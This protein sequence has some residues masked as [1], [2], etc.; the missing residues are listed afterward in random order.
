MNQSDVVPPEAVQEADNL[1]HRFLETLGEDFNTPGA[2]AE[3]HGL[4]R[5]LEKQ[6]ATNEVSLAAVRYILKR[7]KEASEVLGLDL[8]PRMQDILIPADV[9]ELCGQREGARKSKEWKESD[10]L[11]SG[12]WSAASSWKIRRR[13]RGSFR[14]RGHRA[15]RGRLLAPLG[16]KSHGH[17]FHFDMYAQCS[18]APAGA[19]YN[20][21]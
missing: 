16:M 19:P 10:R 1:Y 12:S 2:L 4:T 13:G 8:F 14:R 20:P 17:P 3:L 21:Q 5:L 6:F 7:L 18:G 11:R 9:T 15:C